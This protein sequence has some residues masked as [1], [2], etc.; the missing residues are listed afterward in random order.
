MGNPYCAD[1]M[2]KS[3]A[4]HSSSSKFW[5]AALSWLNDGIDFVHLTAKNSSL[6]ADSNTMSGSFEWLLDVGDMVECKRTISSELLTSS[7]FPM[8]IANLQYIFKY[9]SF[10]QEKL[11]VPSERLDFAVK[12]GGL[13]TDLGCN[14]LMCCRSGELLLLFIDLN[15]DSWIGCKNDASWSFVFIEIGSFTIKLKKCKENR[16]Y[17]EKVIVFDFCF[18]TSVAA[19]AVG[20]AQMNLMF[21]NA[22]YRIHFHETLQIVYNDDWQMHLKTMGMPTAC[23]LVSAIINHCDFDSE[24]DAM[25]CDAVKRRLHPDEHWPMNWYLAVLP[26]CTISVLAHAVQLQKK[27][28]YWQNNLF[29]HVLTLN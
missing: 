27:K 11:P 24:D 12:G 7:S 9:S 10:Q 21:R 19:V 25:E 29:V 14:W 13:S 6:A 22:V 20:I 15:I 4:Q 18:L 23:E 17:K 26:V 2:T 3:S 8:K 5:S 1:I 28:N 16:F